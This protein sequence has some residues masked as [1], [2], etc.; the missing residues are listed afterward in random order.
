MILSCCL[1]F[2]DEGNYIHI[3]NPCA[4]ECLF[5]IFHSFEA[6][7]ANNIS[8]FKWRKNNNIYEYTYKYKYFY[9]NKN[10]I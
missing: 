1:L 8:S 7:I 5:L 3:I 6:G 4:A 10:F 9:E 2:R